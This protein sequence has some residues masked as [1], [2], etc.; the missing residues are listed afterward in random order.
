[1]RVVIVAAPLSARSGVYRSTVE[2]VEAARGRGLD[3]R[4]L[5]GIRRDAAGTPPTAC[6]GITERQ[7]NAHGVAVTAEIRHMAAPF[8]DEADIVIT[9]VPQ[10]DLAIASSRGHRPWRHVS[11]VRGL[12]WPARGEQSRPRSFLLRAA[13]RW[14]LARADAVWATTPLL[15]DEISS[16]ARAV[17]VPA[18][19]PHA[20]RLHDGSDC[21]PLVFAGRLSPE[22]NPGM[23]ISLVRA[24]GHP[25]VLHG[26]GPLATSLRHDAP[27]DV[28]WA[29]WSDSRDVWR[30]TGIFICPSFREAFGRSA[31]EA[32]SAGLP[33]I[34]SDRTG[35]ARQLIRDPDLAARF[36]LPPTALDSWLAATDALITSAPLR[37]RLSEHLSANARH[38]TTDAS[39]DA[40]LCAATELRR[41]NA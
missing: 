23:L 32:A 36:V 10:S 39:L 27:A 37:K 4:A 9:M 19:T 21:G 28:S 14:S 40:A 20:P 31:V 38:L 8:L 33:S 11:W 34:L 16:V 1:M 22:K 25:A 7:V 12:P 41:R 30:S 24:T 17:V 13:A 26:D 35:V 3:W 2:L 18:G 6:D 15:R 29:G 5:I